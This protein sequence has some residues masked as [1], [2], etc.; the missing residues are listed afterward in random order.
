MPLRPTAVMKSWAQDKIAS[1][2]TWRTRDNQTWSDY[3]TWKRHRIAWTWQ[4]TSKDINMITIA[5]VHTWYDKSRHQWYRVIS[6][7]LQS[8]W[9]TQPSQFWVSES[10]NISRIT[11]LKMNTGSRPT[12]MMRLSHVSQNSQVCLLSLCCHIEKNISS[13]YIYCK[14]RH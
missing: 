5:D 4:S 9:S 10:V 8:D 14:S 13:W 12:P 3:R 6:H 11:L 1:G 2:S 7:F